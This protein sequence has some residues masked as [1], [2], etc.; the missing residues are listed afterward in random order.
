M[1]KRTCE[2][3]NAKIDPSDKV[4]WFTNVLT[5]A[6][7]QLVNVMNHDRFT[8]ANVSLREGMREVTSIP[9]STKHCRGF[10]SIPDPTM[11]SIIQ[12]CNN[13]SNFLISGKVEL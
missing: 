1:E 2:V 6:T 10:D 13:T 4:D 7:H 12:L 9:I 8:L 11:L 3:E 5:K